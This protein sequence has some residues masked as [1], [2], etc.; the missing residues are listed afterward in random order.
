MRA[1]RDTTTNSSVTTFTSSH[2]QK[3]EFFVTSDIELNVRMKISHLEV[4]V[5]ALVWE[6]CNNL[7]DSGSN[8]KRRNW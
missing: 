7:G 2:F 1:T 8:L 5:L 3:Y 4:L 6:W